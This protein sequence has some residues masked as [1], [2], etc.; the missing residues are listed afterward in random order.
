MTKVAVFLA[1]VCGL[2]LVYQLVTG[3]EPQPALFHYEPPDGP[4][5]VYPVTPAP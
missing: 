4:A 2:V 5:P 3:P 1:V